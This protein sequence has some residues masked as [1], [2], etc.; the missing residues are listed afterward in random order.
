MKLDHQ[1]TDWMDKL[2]DHDFAI[3]QL[4]TKAWR[5]GEKGKQVAVFV[6]APSGQVES[7]KRP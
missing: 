7:W 2:E 6:A 5:W 4:G 3:E 1:L